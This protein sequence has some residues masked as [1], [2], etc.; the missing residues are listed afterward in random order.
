MGAVDVSR[1]LEAFQ[2]DLAHRASALDGGVGAAQGRRVDGAE[3]GLGCRPDES[4]V[5]KGASSA[6]RW[7][8]ASM[9]GV[10]NME[11]VNI[12]SQKKARLFAF[13]AMTSSGDAGS[14]ITAMRPRGFIEA[15]ISAQCSSVR[16]SEKTWSTSPAPMRFRSSDSGL[17]WSMT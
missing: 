13:S 17:P 3:D 8:R 4:L 7:C 14:S 1:W 6:S 12:I 16:V 15:T 9:S 10:P 11:R 2:H 5:D